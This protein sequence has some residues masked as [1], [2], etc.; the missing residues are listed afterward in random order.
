MKVK[1]TAEARKRRHFRVRRKIAGTA[2][3]PRMC[4]YISNKHLYVQFVDDDARRTLAQVSS[5][6]KDVSVSGHNR[7]AA[8]TLGK[9]AGERAIAQGISS[10]V[11][12]R[13]GFTYGTR[14]KALADAAREAG[15]KF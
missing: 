5:R 7:E 9:L 15:L 14:M 10:V 11:F 3:R 13:G 6:E 4:V 2:E 12:D 8:G 1:T